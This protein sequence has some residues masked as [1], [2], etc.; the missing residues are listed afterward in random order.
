MVSGFIIVYNG[1]FVRF[2]GVIVSCVY[3][4]FLGRVNKYIKVVFIVYLFIEWLVV[5]G[6]SRFY[7]S[8]VSE[9][10]V[11]VWWE[12]NKRL[13]DNRLLGFYFYVS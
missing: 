8:L 11:F 1:L 13:N 10:R 6:F 5:I 2:I 9:Y 7:F 3:R 12:F 4:I